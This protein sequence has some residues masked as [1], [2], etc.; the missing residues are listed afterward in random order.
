MRVFTTVVT[1]ELQGSASALQ[2]P[3][4]PCQLVKFRAEAT[5]AGKVYIGGA[6]VTIPDGTTDATSGW[7]LAA[8]IESGWIPVNSLKAFYRICDNAG[9]DLVYMAL[10]K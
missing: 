10:A 8:G 9:D 1:G 5:N 3:D 7:E 6:G 4:I 2:L